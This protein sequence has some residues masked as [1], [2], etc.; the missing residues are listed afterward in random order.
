ME[1]L[2]HVLSR[3][4]AAITKRNKPPGDK[5]EGLVLPD[6]MATVVAAGNTPGAVAYSEKLL[7]DLAAKYRDKPL[8]PLS[9]EMRAKLGACIPEIT[10]TENV[11]R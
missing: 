11:G 4:E 7:A 8:P 9:A 5:R 6:R 3:F 2:D 1:R 10:D